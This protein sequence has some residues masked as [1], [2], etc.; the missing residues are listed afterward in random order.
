[1]TQAK[2]KPGN[3]NELAMGELSVQE[4]SDDGRKSSS[5]GSVAS[6]FEMPI[7]VHKNNK[8]QEAHKPTS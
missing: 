3:S 5:S 7:S 6:Q 4:S 1:M 2:G 8:A